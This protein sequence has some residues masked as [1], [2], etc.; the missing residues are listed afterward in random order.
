MV[1]TKTS[2]K[3]QV[4]IPITIR[5]ELNI[6]NGSILAVIAEKDLIIFKKVD[7]ELT[8]ADLKTLKLVE[9]AWKDIE[10]GKYKTR[11]KDDFFKE[12]KEW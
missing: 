2:S 10:E 4:V 6:H 9:E 5:K 7:S 11:S 3:G 1:F 12:L 8:P